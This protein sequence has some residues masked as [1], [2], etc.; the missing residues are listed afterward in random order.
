MNFNKN[1]ILVLIFGLTAAFLSS[2]S[3][4]KFVP[5]G[6]Y[7]LNKV[8]I[9]TDEKSQNGRELSQF[10]RQ[11]PNF[12]VFGLHRLHL[13]VYNLAGKDTTKWRNRTLQKIGEKPVI[14]DPFQT[15]RSEREL[16]KYMQ[17]KGYINSQVAV[18]AEFKKKKAKVTY[19]VTANEPYRIRNI[20]FNFSIDHTIDS[21]MQERGSRNTLL[22]QGMLFDTDVL[23]RERERITRLLRRQ[24]YFYFN[25]EYLAYTA[26]SSLRSNQ[27]D[28][29]LNL[30]PF[31]RTHPDGTVEEGK[32]QR[33]TI[34]NVNVLITITSQSLYK[35]IILK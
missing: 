30:K 2:C 26:D 15:Y 32:H 35:L 16:Q 27:V 33:Y 4:T 19:V 3:S 28:I 21:L 11:E 7:L 23:D 8:E 24:G 17:T 13:S 10:L 31:V 12:K 20:Q 25:K 29:T 6:N 18:E 22:T 9:K 14:Y 34:R 1:S 5:E